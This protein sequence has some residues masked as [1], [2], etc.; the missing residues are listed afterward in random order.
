LAGDSQAHGLLP[1][2]S[3][4]ASLV[5][6]GFENQFL[7]RGEIEI[8]TSAAGT[9]NDDFVSLDDN[10]TVK[11]SSRY[12]NHD[13]LHRGVFRLCSFSRMRE[14]LLECGFDDTVERA[15]SHPDARYRTTGG[16]SLHSLDDSIAHTKFMHGCLRS[17][18]AVGDRHRTK[19][20]GRKLKLRFLHLFDPPVA[21]QT[22]N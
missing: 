12:R 16:A 6:D 22:C 5:F 9:D 15:D 21:N 1:I 4:A 17:G 19:I 11:A 14:G 3:I 8:R 7:T 20:A 2:R 10:A 13:E 18:T